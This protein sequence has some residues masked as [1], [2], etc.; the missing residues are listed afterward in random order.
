MRAASSGAPTTCHHRPM[1]ALPPRPISRRAVLRTAVGVT[2][3]GVA[4]PALGLVTTAC[5]VLGD[6]DDDA[7]RSLGRDLAEGSDGDHLATV[8]LAEVTPISDRSQV[9]TALDRLADRIRRD[10]AEGRTVLGDGWLLAET[11]AAV[12]VAYASA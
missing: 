4:A 8:D 6:G 7:L 9:F 3:L 1:P 5:G 11:E 2:A 10:L 12:L